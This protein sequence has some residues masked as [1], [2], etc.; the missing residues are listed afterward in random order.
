MVS[1]YHAID[2]GRCRDLT[3]DEFVAAFESLTLEAERF[4]HPDHVR[5]AY[6]YL[7]QADLL[8]TLRRCADGLRRFAAHH[9]AAERYHET[10][11]WALVVLIHER[12]AFESDPVDLPTFAARNPDLVRWRDGAF[13]DYYAPEILESEVARRTFVLPR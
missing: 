10:V 8:E 6:V 9:G 11:T 13:F 7:R 2:L 5:L 3:D 12:L 1:V 4:R